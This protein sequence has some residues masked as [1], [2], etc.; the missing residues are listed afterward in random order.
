MHGGRVRCNDPVR[1]R[2]T[3]KTLQGMKEPPRANATPP[4]AGISRWLKTDPHFKAT[5]E[6]LQAVYDCPWFAGRRVVRDT[7]IASKNAQTIGSKEPHQASHPPLSKALRS[8]RQRDKETPGCF[9][10]PERQWQEMPGFVQKL[11]KPGTSEKECELDDSRALQ[12]CAG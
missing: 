12:T 1:F 9:L 5:Y 2:K 7:I 8:E 11:N 3:L 10:H 4:K 6:A